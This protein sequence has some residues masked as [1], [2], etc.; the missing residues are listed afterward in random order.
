MFTG[1]RAGSASPTWERWFRGGVK[2]KHPFS[3]LPVF[4]VRHWSGILQSPGNRPQSS[5]WCKEG[6]KERTERAPWS[7]GAPGELSLV[8]EQGAWRA[9]SK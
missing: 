3:P 5:S 9:G 1:H 6:R 8:M 4:L 7:L 2:R